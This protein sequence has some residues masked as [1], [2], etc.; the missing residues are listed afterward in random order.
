MANKTKDLYMQKEVSQMTPEQA[1]AW[2]EALRL[3]WLNF[4]TN[5]VKKP[6]TWIKALQIRANDLT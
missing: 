2:C 5:E 3:D 6:L 1:I 4:N